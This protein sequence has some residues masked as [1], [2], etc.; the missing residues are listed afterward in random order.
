MNE[1]KEEQFIPISELNEL[2]NLLAKHGVNISQWGGGRSR[3]LGQLMEE[4][5]N[6][7]SR[8]YLK[9]GKELVRYSKFVSGSVY[10]KRSDN[11]VLLL[12]E[13]KQ[14]FRDNRK[15]K[16]RRRHYDN[17][18]AEKIMGEES[19]EETVRR[20]LLEEIGIEKQ[21]EEF[22][23]TS[24]REKYLDSMSYPGLMTFF[25]E[26]RFD[27]FINDSEFKPEGYIEERDDITTYFVWEEVS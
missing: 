24:R 17:S 2:Q 14:I 4:I 22:C 10:Y 1:I 26:Y 18:Y 11:K 9:E 23:F 15:E 5:K 21:P 27:I 3:T 20:G 8:L 7:E 13:D 19:P 12:K 16:I 6:G 25:E